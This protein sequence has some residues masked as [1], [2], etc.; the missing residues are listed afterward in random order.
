MWA[1]ELTVDCSKTIMFL[2][3]SLTVGGSEKK[4]VRIAN[5][6]HQRGRNV[7]IAYLN[8][9]ES[10]LAHIDSGV[11]VFCLQ[12]KGKLSLSAMRSLRRLVITRGVSTIFCINLYPTIYA[13]GACFGLSG[14]RRPRIVVTINRTEHQSTKDHRSMILF[15]PLIKRSQLAVFGCNAQL[16][17]WADRYGLDRTKCDVIYNGVDETE[18]APAKPTDDQFIVGTVG[19]LTTVKNQIELVLAFDRFRKACPD[20][21]MV[22]VG[23]G[24]NRTILLRQVAELGIQ[25]SVSLAGEHD[26]VRSAISAMDVFV[27]PSISETFSNAALEAMS[28]AKPVIL[29]DTGGAR[30]MVSDAEDGY[31]YAQGDIDALV[32][33]IDKL[34][35]NESYRI[36]LGRMARQ[37]VLEKFT[38]AGMVDAFEYAAMT[39][40]GRASKSEF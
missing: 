16:E 4:T 27:V 28:M 30:E 2:L 35:R 6:L 7:C 3:S 1:D 8:P 21:R 25:H 23:D 18:F 29:S 26:D 37:K 33:L 14:P 40:A 13:H 10:L 5:E 15:A 20:A 19:R 32:Q 11:T 34:W 31:I 12:R 22:I 39:D 24:P 36:E 17:L 38:F 9:P